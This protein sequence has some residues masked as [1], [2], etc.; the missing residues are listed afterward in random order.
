MG[1]AGIVPPDLTLCLGQRTMLLRP[2][3]AII[4]GYLLSALISP[5]IKDLIGRVAVGSGVKHLRV[6]DVERLPIPM[7]PFAEQTRIVA[8]IDRRF[9][10]I[11]NVEEEVDAN[12]RRAEA[13]R[14]SYL[15]FKLLPPTARGFDS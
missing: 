12:L 14:L 4:A 1:E 13:L 15:A 3:L 6:G 11:R 5:V 10:L 7:P 8:E 9:S 2:S